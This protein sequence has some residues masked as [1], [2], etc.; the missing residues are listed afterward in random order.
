MERKLQDS[1]CKRNRK[2]RVL[3]SS[4]DSHGPTHD[5]I[6]SDGQC[7]P[8]CRISETIKLIKPLWPAMDHFKKNH[9]Y[10]DPSPLPA[11][12][13]AEQNLAA[14]LPRLDCRISETTKLLMPLWLT[15]VHFK[16]NYLYGEP[17]LL[18]ASPEVGRNLAVVLARR[19]CRI[20]ETNKSL[21][22]L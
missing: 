15:I 19:N 20:S 10:G 3:A 1:R 2:A 7:R 14:V 16:K 6:C 8:D 18:P 17:S 4:C 13:K 21:M 11:H 9:L 5:L 12:R 22:R